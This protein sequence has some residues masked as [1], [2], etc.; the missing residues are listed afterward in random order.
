[1]TTSND[2]GCGCKKSAQ[3]TVAAQSNGLNN[4]QNEILAKIQERRNKIQMGVK[5]NL[6]FF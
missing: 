1:M 3:T 5:R 2:T 6:R 4:K